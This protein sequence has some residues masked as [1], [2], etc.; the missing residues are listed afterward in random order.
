MNKITLSII[1]LLISSLSFSQE[2]SRIDHLLDNM[3][4]REKIAQLFIVSFSSNE[5]DPSTISAFD[6]VK[7]EKSLGGVIV[8]NSDLI[9]A[10]NILNR[11]H[12]FSEKIPLLTT[13]DGEWGPAMR[14]GSVIPFPRQMQLGALDSDSLI[15]R[16]GVA[17]GL[18]TKRVG[19]D[20]NFAPSIDINI[21]PK[22]PV[23]NTRSFGENIDKVGQY[24]YAY[25][26]GMMSVGVVGSAKH[27][28]GHGDTE[29][30]SHLALPELPFS[31][32]RIDSVE[33]RPFRRLIEGDVDMVMVAHL[34][35][36]S[37]DDSGR[38]ASISKPIITG[39]L[40]EELGYNGIIITDALN[41]K[42][43]ADYLKPEEIPLEAYKAGCDIILMPSK[44]KEAITVMEEAVKRGEILLDDLNM[45][46]RKM[47]ELKEKLGILESRPLVDLANIER[48]LNSPEYVSLIND[49]AGKSITLIDNSAGVIPIKDLKEERIG[50]LSIGGV[51]NGKEMA[52]YLMRYAA[53]DTVVLRRNYKAAD[54]SK[55]LDRLRA[56]SHII[57][58][59]HNTDFRPH[60]EFGIKKDEIEAIT[61]FAAGH[62]VSF[63]YF[64]NPLAIP[65]IAGRENFA[66][67]ILGYNNTDYNNLAVAQTIFGANGALGRLPLTAGDL[68]EGH[69]IESE[70]GLRLGYGLPEDFN[71][72]GNIIE[73][74]ADT[75]ISGG[76]N[77][78]KFSGAQ[79]LLMHR[80]RVIMN[81]AYG[82]MNIDSVTELGR[83]SRMLTLLPSIASL[84]SEGALSTVDF[85]REHIDVDP[86]SPYED[87]VIADLLMHRVGREVSVG[88]NPRNID[89]LKAIVDKRAPGF[90][91]EF[92]SELFAALGMY[93]TD[94]NNGVVRSNTNDIAKLISLMSMRGNYGGVRY[95]NEDSADIFSQY[96]F[97]YSSDSNGNLVWRDDA[98]DLTLIFLNDGVVPEDTEQADF[99]VGS[100][101]ADVLRDILP[102]FRDKSI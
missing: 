77:S 50:Y 100:I 69:S 101:G 11:M 56:N 14:F 7:T 49:I 15:Y 17:I 58:A 27:F 48:D 47:L 24:G 51:Q 53:V 75:H 95:L 33:L 46:C 10:T 87:A 82:S 91:Q 13:I 70:G 22:N 34:R 66:S 85:I 6:L 80:N 73:S 21:N 63:I 94:Y 71:I 39:L 26:A 41:M 43:V 89:Y 98:D 102:L 57:V 1:S 28:P 23:I 72:A 68:P 31:K 78:G 74:V 64:G 38:P 59:M 60:M 83:I 93:R 19:Y 67:F 86:D 18:Q 45:R 42:G 84:N 8:M 29:V 35:I 55:A 99:Y 96:A 92:S 16:M 76:I 90:E 3:T 88:Y 40:R 32:E 54:I 81:R 44:A 79:L 30:D 37:L 20:V 4:V 12:A 36:P 25:M 62:T 61:S 52:G 5:R 65:Y 9:P 97:Y 2:Q